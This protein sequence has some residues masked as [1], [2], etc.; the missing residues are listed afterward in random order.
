MK[1]FYRLLPLV[2]IFFFPVAGHTAC[3]ARQ[4]RGL[5]GLTTQALGADGVE[6]TTLSLFDFKADNVVNETYFLHSFARTITNAVA[7]GTYSVSPSCS[8]ALDVKDTSGVVYGL[9]G[10]LNPRTGQLNVLQTLP[11]QNTV[12][13]GVMYPVGLKRCLP[14]TF[15]GRYA[16]LTDGRVSPVGK[17][18][19]PLPESRLGWFTAITPKLYQP[20]QWV[21]LNGLFLETPPAEI[22]V[23]TSSCLIDLSEGGFAGVIVDRG[24]RALYM[25]LSAGSVRLGVM[26][27]VR[28]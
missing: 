4:V 15:K 26:S 6:T 27:K 1:P 24:R 21:N 14:S 28:Y 13:M 2:F 23:S 25:D 11:N 3:D 22:A 8:F 12:A 17:L 20:V 7:T 5:Y 18:L 10:Q 9:K 19:S 16:F